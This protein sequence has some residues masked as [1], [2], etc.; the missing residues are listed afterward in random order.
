MFVFVYSSHHLKLSAM[1]VQFVWNTPKKSLKTIK[2][3]KKILAKISYPKSPRIKNFKPKT[4]LQSSLSLQ[5]WST[6]SGIVK[7]VFNY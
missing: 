7:S 6:P 1:N 5:I 3:Q 4:I 2:P